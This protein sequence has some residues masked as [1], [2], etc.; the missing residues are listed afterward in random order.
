MCVFCYFF[1]LRSLGV[2]LS[3]NKNYYYAIT[4]ISMFK[5][6]NC[7]YGISIKGNYF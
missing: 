7:I 1:F 3:T 5:L 6:Q 2:Y 4:A